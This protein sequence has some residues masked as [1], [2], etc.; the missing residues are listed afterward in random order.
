MKK[1]MKYCYCFDSYGN[2][3]LCLPKIYFHLARISDCMRVYVCV[4]VCV[5]MY[6]YL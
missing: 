6:E 2:T 1:D 4:C 5:Y 3:K